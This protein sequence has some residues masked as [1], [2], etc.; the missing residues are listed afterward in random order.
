MS[1]TRFIKNVAKTE[2]ESIL[3]G[4]GALLALF[5]AMMDP[6]VSF[7]IAAILLVAIGVYESVKR[8]KQEKGYPNGQPI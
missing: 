5:M 2:M 6:Y 8:H 1:L 3:A 7:G 4:A